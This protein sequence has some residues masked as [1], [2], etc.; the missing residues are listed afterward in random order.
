MKRLRQIRT[1]QV[2]EAISVKFVVTFNILFLI[3]G[4]CMASGAE[5]QHVL[6]LI[7]RNKYF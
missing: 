4:D 6:P 7:N 1:D 3:S 5:V 2:K